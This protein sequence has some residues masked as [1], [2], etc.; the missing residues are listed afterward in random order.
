MHAE[1]HQSVDHATAE[2]SL[3]CPNKGGSSHLYIDLK[4]DAIKMAPTCIFATAFVFLQ[5]FACNGQS[6]N[7]SGAT[8]Q[9][10]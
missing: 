3:C 10:N 2:T 6:Y 5:L 4:T 1:Q 7:L 8:T 9:M